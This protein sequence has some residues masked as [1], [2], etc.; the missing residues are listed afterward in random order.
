VFDHRG[1]IYE[2]GAVGSGRLYEYGE[3]QN[4][5]SSLAPLPTFSSQTALFLF[6][7]A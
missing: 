6:V 5:I 1:R 3:I 4:L 2:Y 7:I